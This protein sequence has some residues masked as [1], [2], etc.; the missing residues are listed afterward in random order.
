MFT[1]AVFFKFVKRGDLLPYKPTE[2]FMA[3][4]YHLHIIS[5][6]VPGVPESMLYATAVVLLGFVLVFNA[7]AIVLRTRI[8]N[9]KK[10]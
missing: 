6:Q 10:W 5:T 3:L 8:R 7:I 4:S 1:G 9:R 2:Q